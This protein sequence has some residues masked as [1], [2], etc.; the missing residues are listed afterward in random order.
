M[1]EKNILSNIRNAVESRVLN[2]VSIKGLKMATAIR[3]KTKSSGKQLSKDIVR[4]ANK[5][6]FV[7]YCRRQKN[8]RY[9]QT[10]IGVWLYRLQP[11]PK[12]HRD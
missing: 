6:C 3:T 5:R 8:Y 9:K 1:S 4:N 12:H 11:T 2:Y 7:E 10:P